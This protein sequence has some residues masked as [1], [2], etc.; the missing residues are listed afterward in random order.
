MREDEWYDPD[1]VYECAFCGELME[2]TGYDPCEVNV[3]AARADRPNS[4]QHWQF[5][6]HAACVPAAFTASLRDAAGDS[7]VPGNSQST[8]T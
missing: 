6:V 4:S 8:D 2:H 3:G 1:S 7:Y 5:W